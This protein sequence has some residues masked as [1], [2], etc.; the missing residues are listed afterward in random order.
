[1]NMLSKPFLDVALTLLYTHTALADM[2]GAA[3]KAACLSKDKTKQAICN[4]SLDAVSET[5]RLTTAALKELLNANGYSKPMP[6]LWC[7]PNPHS[8]QGTPFYD[9]RN[10]AH[11]DVQHARHVV[12]NYLDPHAEALHLTAAQLVIEALTAA[13]PPTGPDRSCP[14]TP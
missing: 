8:H 3:L 10:D 14:T 1:M 13:Y 11:V 12:L 2:E 4:T 7:A 5:Q 9:A 6:I